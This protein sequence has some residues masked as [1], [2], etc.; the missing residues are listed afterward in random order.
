M[1]LC[2]LVHKKARRSVLIRQGGMRDSN[3]RSPEPQS[4]ALTNYANPTIVLVEIDYD[5][6]QM[7]SQGFE[8][9]TYGLEGRCSI[10]LSYEHILLS[11][12]W[13]NEL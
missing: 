2:A 12:Y 6:L 8:T 11:F 1:T 3:P 9:W 4:G 13:L 5:H 10:Q 7:C